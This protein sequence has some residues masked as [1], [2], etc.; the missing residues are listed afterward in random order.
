MTYI[1]TYLFNSIKELALPIAAAGIAVVI[2]SSAFATPSVPT[3]YDPVTGF[4]WGM[5]LS[6]S[7]LSGTDYFSKL[8]EITT[9][10]YTGASLNDVTT[11]YNDLFA[12]LGANAD[13]AFLTAFGL[14]SNLS[15]AFT[16]TASPD[17]PTNN[18]IVGTIFS[19]CLPTSGCITGRTDPSASILGFMY[20]TTVTPTPEPSMIGLFGGMMLSMAWIAHRKLRK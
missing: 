19:P 2:G 11:M 1:H 18:F 6:V 15:L 9:A 4:T 5:P 14:A 10:G 12:P 16:T 7:L 17:F 3:I 13:S 20:Y 8:G